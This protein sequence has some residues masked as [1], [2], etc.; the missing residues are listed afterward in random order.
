VAL[1]STI[2]VT[3]PI[4]MSHRARPN[5]APVIRPAAMTVSTTAA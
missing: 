1:A 3:T 2:V 5:H 4:G